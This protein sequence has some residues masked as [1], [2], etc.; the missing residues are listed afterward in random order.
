MKKFALIGKPLGH[1]LSPQIHTLISEIT[2]VQ[3]S[4]ELRPLEP[5]EVR[6]F[7]HNLSSEGLDG[8]NVTIPYKLTAFETVDTLSPEAQ[9][10]G[11]VNTIEVQ[12]GGLVGHN[13]DTHGFGAMLQAAAIEV[14][15]ERCVILGSGG[16]ARAAVAWLAGHGASEVL[17]ASRDKQEA[18]ARFPGVHVV[19]YTELEGI[20]GGLLVNCTPLGMHPHPAGCP[21][22]ESIVGRFSSVADLVYNPRE[23]KLLA[24]AA[25]LG[26]QRA[27][28][29]YMLASQAVRAREIWHGEPMGAGVERQVYERL[30]NLLE[31]SG[32]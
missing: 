2:G 18:S 9:A 30:A 13:T 12:P 24:I 23:T 22:S 10:V 20:T 26:L 8:L 27:D 1:S 17:I 4:Y 6:P 16:A 25:R 11:A 5:D 15:G 19:S 7:L 3:C 14:K 29:I 21:V 28:G 31:E 32:K